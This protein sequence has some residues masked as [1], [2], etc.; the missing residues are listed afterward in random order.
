MARINGSVTQRQD[1][2]E[3]YII[4]EESDVNIANNTSKITAKS[5]IYC[6]KHTAYNYDTYNH[7]IT[8]DGQTFTTAVDGISLSAGVT[9]ELAVGS[10][11]I[12][13]NDDGSK[14]ITI[15]AS[16]PKL[17]AGNGYGPASGSASG[18]A[19]LT[20]IPRTS[21][22]TCADGNIGSS[23]VINISRASSSFRHTLKYVFGN[24]S[25]IIADKTNDISIGWN[26]PTSFY[27]QIPNNM[28]GRGAISCE[29]YSGDTLVG[30]SGCNFNAF[31]VNSNPTINGNAIDVNDKTV[32]LTGNN[33]KIVKYCSN[34][35]VDI[36][37]TAQNSASITY[38]G[39]SAGNQSRDGSS[40]ILEA[41]ETNVFNI[42]CRDSRG[43]PGNNTIVKT[44]VDYIKVAFTNI[45]VQRTTTTSNTVN[46]SLRGNY[47]NNSFGAVNNALILKFRSRLAN[48][49]WG[50][51]IHLNA[52][53]DGNTFN[54]NGELGTN[55]DYQNAYEFEFYVEDKLMTDVKNRPLTAGQPIIDIGKKNV[56]V[57]GILEPKTLQFPNNTW[58]N[59]GDDVTMGDFNSAGLLGIKGLN[60]NTG[61][62]FHPYQGNVIQNMIAD[63]NGTLHLADN[64]VVYGTMFG[65]LDGSASNIRS[66]G[67]A[68]P[69]TGQNP[70]QINGLSMTEAYNNGYPDTYGTILNLKGGG[71]SSSQL[72]LGWRG[73]SNT[74]NIFYRSLRDFTGDGTVWGDWVRIVEERSRYIL[75]NETCGSSSYMQ[76][77][78]LV[79]CWGKH[80][81]TP[82][83]NQPT[84]STIT[85]PKSYLLIPLVFAMPVTSVPGTTVVGASATAVSTTGCKLWVTRT[86]TT[87]TDLVWLAIGQG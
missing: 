83:A 63:G 49:N 18:T 76:L 16:S 75:S 73:S 37:A 24:L 71:S 43:L 56:R 68:N 28:S 36:V 44:L 58:N 78:N 19:T 4:W 50:D 41:V 17:P 85:F 30:T 46:V 61:I 12:K 25:G 6:K 22:V 1:A 60:G 26:I 2:Y 74:G 66:R 39:V 33:N 55:F 79:I 42:T 21:N 11:V 20:T 3:F 38:V 14:S 48:G 35:K 9:K 13:H 67:V 15:S 57:N 27:N 70:I 7:T 5:Y 77:G 52:N 62:A 65:T 45:E 82:V 69:E 34:V 86:N 87:E 40:V 51:Y 64:F 81:I 8:I 72:F 53:I 80:R 23:T 31:V 59:V 54:Y 47:F 32:A 29:T 10:K 84:S